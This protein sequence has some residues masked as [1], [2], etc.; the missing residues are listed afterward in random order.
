LIAGATTGAAGSQLDYQPEP[1]AWSVRQ[2]VCHLADMEVAAA[3][4]LRKIIAE[5]NP[6]LDIYDP[7]AWAERLHYEQRKFSPALESFRR[8]RAENYE[9]LSGL[10]PAEF[11]RTGR[12]PKRGAVTLLDMLRLFAEHAEKH[13]RQIMRVREAYK[14]SRGGG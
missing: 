12:H 2:I 7:D 13:A 1:G 9:L 8:T 3:T 5:E 4:R 11:T 6:P 14:K 10:A